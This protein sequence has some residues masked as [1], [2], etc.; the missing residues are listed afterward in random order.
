MRA[1]SLGL[2]SFLSNTIIVTKEIISKESY[3]F[4]GE[5]E[6]RNLLVSDGVEQRLNDLPREPRFLV[7]VHLDHALPVVGRLQQVVPF[8]NIDL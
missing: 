8:A 5:T 6:H 2:G 1:V 4:E 7:I 3:L